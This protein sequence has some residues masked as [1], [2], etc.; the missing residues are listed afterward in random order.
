MVSF[1]AV[2]DEA[3][4]DIA[5]FVPVGLEVPILDDQTVDLDTSTTATD[6]D[7]SQGGH[8]S[9]WLQKRLVPQ[10]APHSVLHPSFA[11]LL[12]HCAPFILLTKTCMPL[13]NLLF[14]LSCKAIHAAGAAMLSVCTSCLCLSMQ[15]CLRGPKQSSRR[16][17]RCRVQGSGGAG[18]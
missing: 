9:V 10:G 14:M 6:A 16:L 3:Q 1:C 11:C 2:Q 15:T 12:P 8:C 18:A 7:V 4:A 5:H 17:R 13:D